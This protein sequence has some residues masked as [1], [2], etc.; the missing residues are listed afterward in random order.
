MQKKDSQGISFGF[1]FSFEMSNECDISMWK[2]H[3]DKAMWRLLKG[4]YI[5]LIILMISMW[6]LC[7][8]CDYYVQTNILN[9]T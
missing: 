5:Y 3:S 6:L 7:P 8:N 9:R 2:A 4:N 1:N